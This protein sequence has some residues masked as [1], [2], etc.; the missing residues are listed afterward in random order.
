MRRW[1]D[2]R[3]ALFGEAAQPAAALRGENLT[4]NPRLAA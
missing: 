2:G 1:D 4:L 3:A